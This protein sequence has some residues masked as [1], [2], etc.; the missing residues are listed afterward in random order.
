[1]AYYVN[2]QVYNRV[3]TNHIEALK[4]DLLAADQAAA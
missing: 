2:K 1:M 3:L 4:A